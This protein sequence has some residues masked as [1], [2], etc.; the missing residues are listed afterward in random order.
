MFKIVQKNAVLQKK[1]YLYIL[2]IEKTKFNNILYCI[3]N[4]C[5]KS[6]YSKVY[7]APS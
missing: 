7:I 5:F 2:F 1:K 4:I 3:L 6:Y